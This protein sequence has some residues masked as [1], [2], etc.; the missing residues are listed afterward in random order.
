MVTSRQEALLLSIIQEYIDT[1]EPVSSKLIEKSGFFGLSSATIRAEMNDLESGGYLAH[2]YTSSGRVPTDRAFR[3][4]VDNLLSWDDCEADA[5]VKQKVRQVFENTDPDPQGLART[6]AR[7]VADLSDSMVITN[8]HQRQDFY[9][10]GLSSLFE[11]R[12]FQELSRVFQLTHFF[13]QFEELF[14]TVEQQMIA[15]MTSASSRGDPHIQICIGHENPLNQIK[16]ETVMYASYDLPGR[17]TG[18]IT[19]V[20]P[21]RM[22]YKK[23][24]GIIRYATEE[25][26]KI[27]NNI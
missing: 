11:L 9:K 18:T 19:L 27:A 21:T 2:L 20:G 22:D 5:Q 14:E 3:Y 12:E 6:L 15:S 7:L 4:F 24:I 16:G 17:Y 10:I 1:G 8:I 26:N 13:D 23:N 25:L